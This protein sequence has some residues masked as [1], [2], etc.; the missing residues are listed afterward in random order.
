MVVSD[1]GEWIT[2]DRTTESALSGPASH[3]DIESRVVFTGA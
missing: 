2:V 3:W 1:A